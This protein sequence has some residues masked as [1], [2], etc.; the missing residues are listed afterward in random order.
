ML[1]ARVA[2]EALNALR[3]CCL[4]SVCGWISGF[5]SGVEVG[6]RTK[7][8]LESFSTKQKVGALPHWVAGNRYEAIQ[9]TL[10]GRILNSRPLLHAA[11]ASAIGYD[12]EQRHFIEDL[13]V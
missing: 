1:R 9:N 8:P 6:F 7:G 4:D 5:S 13:F 3:S 2:D 10:V 11:A 12:R